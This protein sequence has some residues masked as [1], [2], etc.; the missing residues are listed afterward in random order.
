MTGS[1]R[2]GAALAI[3]AALAGLPRQAIS[4]EMADV[5]GGKDH[6]LVSRYAGSVMLG[7]RQQFD[8]LVIPLADP[9]KATIST[10]KL[11]KEVRV[12]GAATRLLYL[13]PEGRSPLEVVRNYEGEL[14]RAGFQSLYTCAGDKCTT[15]LTQF[16][17]P[18]GQRLKYGNGM[19]DL[20]EMAFSV[21]ADARYLVLKRVRP[22]GEAYVSLFVGVNNLHIPAELNMRTIALLDVVV[23]AGMDTGMVTVDAASM[24][25]E[26]GKSGHVALYGI[27]FDTGKAAVKPASEPALVEIAKLL[28]QDPALKLYVVGHTDNVGAFEQNMTLSDRRAAAVV[29]E[30]TLRHGVAAPRLRPVGVGPAAPVAPNDQEEGRAKNRR[31]ELVAQ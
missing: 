22:D 6:P 10:W 12:E 26:M 25:R 13:I 19:S 9:V 23:K 18:G 27:L 24:A 31:V 29:Q 8:E 1:R 5:K 21:I 14:G 7:Y 11:A 30:L 3:A 16:L 17:Y 28:K 15:I 4:A 2:V 20:A